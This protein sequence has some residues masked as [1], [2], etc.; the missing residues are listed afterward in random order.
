MVKIVVE[1]VVCDN[2]IATH[3]K[4]PVSFTSPSNYIA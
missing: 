3:L 2:A 4:A 1:S